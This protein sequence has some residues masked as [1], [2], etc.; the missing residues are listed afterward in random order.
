MTQ[1][2]VAKELQVAPSYYSQWENGV[3]PLSA[4]YV[5]ALDTLFKTSGG[6]LRLW[7]DLNRPDA[8]PPGFQELPRLERAADRLRDY[9]PLLVPGLFQTPEYARIVLECERPWEKD[10]AVERLVEARLARQQLLEEEGAPLLAV[11]LDEGVLR[12]VVGSPEVMKEQLD[13]LHAAGQNRRISL[14]VM[15][16]ATR[17]RPGLTGPFRI[18]TFHERPEVV[19]AEYAMGEHLLDRPED[20]AAY[21]TLFSILQSEALPTAQSLDLIKKVRKELDEQ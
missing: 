2:Q 11:V 1:A 15:P 14:Q 12:R 7:Q 20:L 19:S 16:W 3:R 13:R 4:E 9:G 10:G 8:L 17:R 18:Y 5:H 21:N 6:L